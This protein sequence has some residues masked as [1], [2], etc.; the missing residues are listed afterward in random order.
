MTRRI[1][2]I[3]PEPGLSAT[4]A[5]GRA[6]ELEI[7]GCPLFEIRPVSWDA[8]EPDDIDALLIGSANAV[9]HG[10]PE[11]AAFV[12]KPAFA[13]GKVTAQAL[14]AAGFPV[15]A[16]GKGG[17]QP[18]LDALA[19]RNLRLLRLSG[20]EH[21]PIEVPAGITL[22]TRIAYDVVP[23]PMPPELT[24][25]LAAGGVTLLHSGAAARHFAAEYDRAGLNRTA[26]KLA[27]LGPRI[28]DAAGGGWREVRSA[29]A[30]REAALLALALD[31]CH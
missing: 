20:E 22:I 25:A 8:P 16:V 9:R 5:A 24:A 29:A 6:A 26:M 3:R 30:P 28:A 14:K 15:A 10:G 4:I 11:L 19:G 23:L 12:G 13:V 31:M 7:E 21:V 27:A 1:F 18:L 17:L 2:A